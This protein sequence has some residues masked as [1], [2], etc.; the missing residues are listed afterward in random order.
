MVRAGIAAAAL[1]TAISFLSGC[2]PQAAFFGFKNETH[3]FAQSKEIFG[4]PMMGYAPNAKKEEVSDDV[5]L[6]Y[7]EVTWKE[8]EPKHGVY[9]WESVCPL[10]RR[11]KTS[12]IALSM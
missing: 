12:C 7:V 1:A 10:A 3:E 4:N 2:N 9:D 6:L 8:L 5:T 11:R